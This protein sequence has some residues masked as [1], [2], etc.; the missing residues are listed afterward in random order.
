[1]DLSRTAYGTW[2]GGRYMHFG[3]ALAADRFVTVIQHA[4]QRG[5]RTFMTADVYGSGAADQ[6][7]GLALAALPRASSCLGGAVRPAF[8]SGAPAGTD[9]LPLFT[10]PAL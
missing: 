1:M 8:S 4:Y 7:V 3:E 10:P 5:I 9:G 6:M 2:S